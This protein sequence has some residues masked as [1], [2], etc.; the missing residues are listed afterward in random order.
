MPTSK[1]FVSFSD[2]VAEQSP[3][4]PALCLVSP[5]ASSK[6]G[7]P[8]D[9]YA[10]N[11]AFKN[12]QQI[13]SVAAERLPEE[14]Y[15]STLRVR[16]SG[17]NAS[18]WLSG[19]TRSS[20]S[21]REM[22]SEQR[23]ECSALGRDRVCL[24]LVNQHPSPVDDCPYFE[25]AIAFASVIL[26]IITNFWCSKRIPAL[27]TD[28]F[29]SV[30][31]GA[32]LD[33]PAAVTTWVLFALLKLVTGVLIIFSWRIL[34][35]PTVQ[36]LLPP[37]FRWL[38]WA[39]PY[40]HGPPHTL[41]AVP[42]MIDLDM[43]VA[44][45]VNEDAGVASGRR[46]RSSGVVKRRGSPSGSVQEKA[47]TFEEAS[48]GGTGEDGEV[49]HC[50]A[51]VL[52][53]V[54]VYVGI[55]AIAT[56]MVPA[57][58]EA[59]EWAIG[60]P[61]GTQPLQKARP[62]EG[63]REP[64]TVKRH[65]MKKGVFVRGSPGQSFDRRD[66]AR[67]K[68]D[69]KIAPA[70]VSNGGRAAASKSPGLY[71]KLISGVSANLGP[72]SIDH[73]PEDSLSMNNGL[74]RHA[75]L[76]PWCRCR[77]TFEAW[78][79]AHRFSSLVTTHWTMEPELSITDIDDRIKKIQN[80]A[81][82]FPR[83]HS[84]HII[85]VHSLA[86][87][88]FARYE[89]SRE[90]EDLDRSIL[91]FTEAILLPPVSRDRPFL[92]IVDHLFALARALLYRSE[93]FERPEDVKYSIEYL[94]YLRRLPLDSFDLSK[95]TVTT[96]LI[97]ALCV[98]L[99]L[100]AGDGT[101]DVNET[102]DLCREFLGPN[103]SA[104]FPVAAFL[105]LGGVV[106]GEWVRGRSVESLDKVVECL[107]DAAGLCPPGSESH[108]LLYALAVTFLTRFTET[109]SNED[110][111]EGTAVLERILDPNQPGEDP[112]SVR[113][114]AL[115][116]ASGFAF[117]RSVIFRNPE[118]SEITISRLRTLLN[119]SSIHGR[120][121]I[122]NT[123]ILAVETRERFRRYNLAESLEEANSYTSQLVDLS[124]S[125]S[126]EESG[127][128]LLG[129]DP[130]QESYPMERM[131]QEIQHLEELLP[132]TPLGTPQHKHLLSELGEWYKSKYYHTN[133]ISDIEE[134]IKYSRLSLDATHSHDQLRAIP[135]GSL[136]DVLV[137]AFEK[138]SKINYLHES[139][140]IGYDI[141][142]V[143]SARFIH[144]YAIRKLVSSLLTREALLGR[145]EDLLEAIRLM[146]MAVDNQYAQEPDRFRLSSM[147]KDCQTM[148]LEYAS[149]QIKLGRFEK[150]V[151]ILEQGRALLWSEMRGLRTPMVQL[152]GEDPS[153]AKRFTDIN[154]E[155]EALTI[156]ITPS[157]RPEVGDGVGQGSDGMDPFGRLVVKQRKL[158]VERDALI[159]QIRG[160]PGLEGFLKTP[161][162][163][164]LRSAALRG[165]VIVIN[166]CEWRSD[167]L[168]IFH[169]SLPCSVPTAGDFY[170]RAN[171]LRDELVEARKHGLDS[172]EY[173]DALC[174]VLKG[175]YE[176]VGQPVIKRL[177]ILGVPEQS[178]V[179]WCPTSVFC[180]LPL[181]AM[182]PIPSSGHPD[183]YFSDLYIPSYTPSL[184][185][186]I[187]SRNAS[188]QMLDKPSLL[189]VAQPEDSLK[190]VK[191][192]IKVIR[193]LEPRV[194]VVG[195]VSS[196]ATPSSVVEGLRGSRFA[197]FA[198]HGVLETGKP[199]DASFKLHRGSR[200]TLLDIARSRL[201]DAEFAFLA[202][203]HAAETTQ[204]SVS[205]EA[206]HLT[207]A[208]QYCGFRSVV[209]TMWEMAD[210]DGR[211]LANFFYKS[212][213]SGQETSVPYYERSA[214]ALRDATQKL[215]GKRG[216]T[217]E[218]WV[219]FV[220]YGA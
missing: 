73:S 99:R 139:I 37:L 162:F 147:G 127:E 53:K 43:S 97:R 181:H 64:S 206:L 32:A 187:E 215:R 38:A 65:G 219:N 45:V 126:L 24:L 130:V 3:N 186:L 118:Y 112:Y 7:S 213:F 191:G 174:S 54:V 89:L 220:H 148:P 93:K 82:W 15:T 8:P 201:P 210:V 100:E 83:P 125:Q 114:L 74:G 157:G 6:P 166:H 25:D 161:S 2:E 60:W 92:N 151:E 203:C 84:L 109:H 168:I 11:V 46:G 39:S 171:K 88:R 177:R 163:T 113:D 40:V 129:S 79:A 153:L 214:G 119:S 145:R 190:G 42:S 116:L 19:K 22:G 165:P 135:L 49:K 140:T 179:W 154:Q 90:K 36:T 86:M 216:I 107:R 69:S 217:L 194:T 167:I 185:A 71:H 12:F 28:L 98:Q 209:G 81:S 211:D 132:N 182:G 199:F 169:S 193:S 91:H 23:I 30:T 104:D 144:F 48:E 29:T 47:V 59:L 94:R 21:G 20:P 70:S 50:D 164:A 58:F 149:F 204:D 35:K 63:V 52:T 115:D 102:V 160:G 78:P 184:S 197:H 123:R 13:T 207:A 208:M 146:S 158:V 14:I 16:P 188:P 134:S 111:E 176:L 131:T 44:E 85:G 34:A 87:A 9:Y 5:P 105:P 56:V 196:E 150:A 170:N 152:T 41:R 124:S 172:G 67:R 103:I 121:R 55:G 156:S 51:D 122:V 75:A 33:S 189:L 117:A 106:I 155:L 110:Y 72:A 77:H 200:L 195:L 108:P 26:G 198:C 173:Q 142:A 31:P 4:A 192:E 17:V 68:F 205:D 180:S 178:R 138:T 202:C 136:H 218:R 133:D 175:L 137:L 76:Y 101:Q 183:R 1:H 128:L 159:S 61:F 10:P 95:H 62:L 57:L 80:A 120:S 143:N 96:F 212:L 66:R 27:N 18:R 141:L